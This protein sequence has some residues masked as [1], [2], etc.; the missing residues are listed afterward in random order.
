MS[1]RRPDLIGADLIGR[2]RELAAAC[3]LLRQESVRLLTLTGPGGVGKTSLAL[4]VADTLFDEFALVAVVSLAPLSDPANVVAALV[5]ALGLHEEGDH[6]LFGR[7]VAHLGSLGSLLVFD[8]FEHLLSATSLLTDLFRAC[9]GLKLLVTSRAVLRLRSE[10]EFPVPPLA[11]DDATNLFLQRAR[12]RLPDFALTPQN[13]VIVQELCARLDGLPLA[14]EL[15]AARIRV[16]TPAALLARLGER[17]TLLSGGPTDAPFRQRTLRNAI[18]WSYELL[19][20]N[21]QRAL[22]RLAVFAGDFS[23]DAA[24]AILGDDTAALDLLDTLINNSLIAA[25]EQAENIPNFSMLETIREF[26]LEQLARSD[27]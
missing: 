25:R 9:P 13:T 19:L 27:E 7:I 23:L 6:N 5:Q 20:P 18:A 10:H 8:N 24:Q 1:S 4:H 26:A 21:Q 17:L 11:I 16:L 3:H 22:C 14:I 2:S 15:A 12:Q